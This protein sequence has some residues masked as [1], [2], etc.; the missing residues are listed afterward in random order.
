MKAIAGLVMASVLFPAVAAAKVKVETVEY[1]QGDTTLEGA[2]AFDDAVKGPRPAVI[3]VH[4]WKG[5]GPYSRRRTEMIAGLG[6][7]GFE[8]DIYGKGVRPASHEEAGKV[9]GVYRSDRA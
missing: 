8:A 5:P 2:F 6:Y 4:E 9:S 3:V 1:K 7:V